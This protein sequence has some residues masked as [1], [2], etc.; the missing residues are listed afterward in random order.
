[1]FTLWFVTPD[2]QGSLNMGTFETYEAAQSA[3]AAATEE[4]LSQAPGPASSVE[5]AAYCQQVNA[6]RWS[7]EENNI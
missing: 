2:E 3:V 4:L 5:H 6:G 1:M 7:I